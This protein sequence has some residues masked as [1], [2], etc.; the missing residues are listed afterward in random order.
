MHD[1]QSIVWAAG[2]ENN[3]G[4]SCMLLNIAKKKSYASISE[5]ISAV[6]CQTA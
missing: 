2:E 3:S 6:T 5:S 1:K 4:S